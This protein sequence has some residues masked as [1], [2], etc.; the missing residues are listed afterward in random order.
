MDPVQFIC[1]RFNLEIA[2]NFNVQIIT[3]ALQ[4]LE[5]TNF[6]VTI[7]TYQHILTAVCGPMYNVPSFL[8][9]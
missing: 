6:C 8:E 4:Y 5:T 3:V 1:R 2:G 9:A 7:V